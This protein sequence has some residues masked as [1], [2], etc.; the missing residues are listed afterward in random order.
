[1]RLLPRHGNVHYACASGTS[2][3]HELVVGDKVYVNCEGRLLPVTL[4][5]H[6]DSRCVG[7]L[8]DRAARGYGE[9]CIEFDVDAIYVV[10]R[11]L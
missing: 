8:N 11:G 4:V 3:T 6:A 7:R 9:D 2:T 1:M 10:Q 5:S